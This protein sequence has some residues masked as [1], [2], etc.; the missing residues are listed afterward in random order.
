MD[1]ST[2]PSIGQAFLPTTTV[3]AQRTV[4][5]LDPY[6]EAP[7]WVVWR[8]EPRNGKKTKVPYGPNTR[9]EAKA[10]D[11][12]T[13]GT[14]YQA[15]LSARDIRSA[16]GLGGG[17]GI[18]FSDLGNGYAMGGIDLDACRSEDGRFE[19]WAVEIICRL[20]SYTEISPSG[21][22]AKTFFLYRVAELPRIREAMG[23]AQWG[24]MF[25]RKSGGEH[26]PGIEFYL[27]HRFFTVTFQHLPN[28]PD[29]T[30]V[31]DAE[32]LLWV[33]REVGPRCAM[34][35]D[36]LAG[37]R[38]S[39]ISTRG[40]L[41]AATVAAQPHHDNSR[42]GTVFRMARKMRGEGKTEE[43]FREAVRT[44]PETMDW[45]TEK[46]TRNNNY[47]LGRAWKNAGKQSNND[48]IEGR[49]YI[50]CGIYNMSDKGLF[51]EQ[52]S[53]KE[54][55]SKWVWA[56]AP[57]E[58]LGQTRD[59]EGGAWGLSIRWEDRDGTPHEWAMPRSMT[60][61]QA[62]ELKRALQEG[63]LK[64]A[65]SGSGLVGYLSTVEPKGRARTATQTGWFSIGNDRAFVLPGMEPMIGGERVILSASAHAAAPYN[66][67]GTLDEWRDN[68]SIP[69]VGNSRLVFPVSIS[70]VG[71]T[72]EFVPTDNTTFNAVGVSQSGK[73]STGY[74]AGSVW[75][76][77][78]EQGFKSSWRA[79]A[80]GLEGEAAARNGTY[81]WLDELG[82]ASGKEVSDNVYQLG[83]GQG[84]AR[85]DRT[86]AARER[87][88]WRQFGYSTGEIAIAEKL[89]EVGK[90]PM[91]GQTV[92]M[93]DFP[94]D[95]GAGLGAFERIPGLDPNA[96]ADARGAAAARFAQQIKDAAVRY[97]GTA[98]RRYV[99]LLTDKLKAD[100]DFVRNYV[101]QASDG[102]VAAYLPPGGASQVRSVCERFALVAAAGGLATEL[103]ITG[104][105][106]GEAERAAAA[107]FGAWL[108]ERG[109]AGNHEMEAAI[110]Q[111]RAFI[112]AHGASRFE[113]PWGMTPA[114][115][116]NPA[117]IA[118]GH[119]H[120]PTTQTVINR[121]GFRKYS[122]KDGW[123]LYMVTP[124]VWKD[125]VCK[126]YHADKVA[127]EMAQ[128]A[129]ISPG[130]GGKTSR[131]VWVP[132]QAGTVRAYVLNPT[133]LQ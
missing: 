47:E 12:K 21:T 85:A 89:A 64:F 117:A 6:I 104:W 78:D 46:G 116:G 95:A 67:S 22:G 75:G 50:S 35:A 77:G 56:S 49:Q 45:Y 31:V 68:V 97:Y 33:L 17:F 90:K 131:S 101:R 110:Q 86:G 59:R 127:Q 14:F 119:P 19:P 28:T 16:L 72:L 36:P 8:I 109:H 44:D 61:G 54:E 26:P 81:I 3:V 129:L 52:L 111:V 70:L 11:P 103:G 51:V 126:G 53:K 23:G 113:N 130:P 2:D 100:P 65:P 106:D 9:R 84:K 128:R 34:N 58:V 7:L 62:D 115:P 29:E 92:R 5:A 39:N 4:C 55:E 79:T 105:P 124:G 88:K 87:A 18:E 41:N 30:R 63:G 20:K 40:S 125:E 133:L 132:G 114:I 120:T 15:M 43:E 24:K 82:L 38:P 123:W 27:G 57:I 1:I 74:P 96:D 69:C 99:E 13:W 83:N 121:A 25:K 112:E 80:N 118:A 60:I 94:A 122:K 42:S 32:D 98:G 91:A 71:P 76:G 102:F 48:I 73:T 10:D 107:C 108:T 93:I 66:I 37:K